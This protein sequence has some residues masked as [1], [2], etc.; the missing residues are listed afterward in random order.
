MRKENKSRLEEMGKKLYRRNFK[1]ETKDVR[2]VFYSEKANVSTQ[3]KKEEVKKRPKPKKKMSLLKKMFI[4]SFSFF[5]VAFITAGFIFWGGGNIVS[6]KN[7]DIEI[8]GPVSVSGGEELLLQIVITNNNST[9]LQFTDLLVEYPDGSYESDNISK[10][11]LRTRKS[12]DLINP[13]ESVNEIVRSVIFGEEGGE[14]EI[15][16]TLEY[17]V[18]GSN[19]IFVKEKPYVLS[20]SSAPINIALETNEEANTGQEMKLVVNI[21]SN[22]ESIMKDVSVRMDYPSGFEPLSADPTPVFGNNIWKIGD[23]P[24]GANLKIEILGIL[25]GQEDDD[26]IFRAYIGKQDEKDER[27]IAVVY[28]SA[29]A[30]T[31]IKKPFIGIALSVDGKT[32]EEFVADSGKFLKGTLTWI[33]NLPTKT[34]NVAIELLILG[35]V[36]EPTS[37]FVDRGVYHSSEQKIIWDKRTFPDLAEVEP[38][39]IGRLSFRFSTKDLFS[40]ALRLKN[41][42]ITLS[43]SVHGRTTGGV[44]TPQNVQ[45]FV[46]RVVKINSDLQLS[47][48]AVYSVGPFANSGPL[49]PKVNNATTYTIVWTVVN[50]SNDV[51]Q[52]K[53]SANIPPY[54]SWLGQIS[55]ATEDVSF[56]GTTGEIIWD[57]GNVDAGAGVTLPAKEIAFQISV[58]PSVAHIGSTPDILNDMVLEGKDDFTGALLEFFKPS[59]NTYLNS[60]PSFNDLWAR[61]V[62]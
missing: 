45:E 19:A 1:Q 20:I 34:E 38:G 59:L 55:P 21:S 2:P 30:Q 48:R 50:S 31:T 62:K 13:G 39:E 33:N 18:E 3:W 15:N 49:P 42:K 6:S 9:P 46:E 16:V 44:D 4:M 14:K 58:T 7:V 57:I 36:L 5:V 56:D 40:D 23:V 11:L 32:E 35:E 53:V 29:V 51:S 26:K 8:V 22:T 28:S 25:H 52:A 10:P 27:E 54:A 47:A 37:V 17:R 12:L 41:P 43:A 24:S 61:V 60:D